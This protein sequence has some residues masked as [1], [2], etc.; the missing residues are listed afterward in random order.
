MH[1]ET[2]PMETNPHF[3]VFKYDS[4]G[5]NQCIGFLTWRDW[6]RQPIRLKKLCFL[7]RKFLNK[8]SGREIGAS[9]HVHK[10]VQYLH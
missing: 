8:I 3:N 10:L 1:T 4:E 5:E 7:Q 6:G 9:L 2:R